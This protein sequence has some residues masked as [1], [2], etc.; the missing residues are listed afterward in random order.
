MA[1]TAAQIFQIIQFLASILTQ[2]APEIIALVQRRE[3][4]G[5]ENEALKV[6][7]LKHEHDLKDLPILKVIEIGGKA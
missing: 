3:Q 6:A 4:V 5:K 1:L 2:I 7:V